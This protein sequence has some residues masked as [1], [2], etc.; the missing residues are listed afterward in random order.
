[1]QTNASNV[2]NASLG[3]AQQINQ[4]S[5]LRQ[6]QLAQL[7]EN[8]K[9]FGKNYMA[10][11][12]KNKQREARIAYGQE[13]GLKPEVLNDEKIGLAAIADALHARATGKAQDFQREQQASEF[14]HSDTQHGIGANGQYDPAGDPYVGRAQ[15]T[16]AA[17]MGMKQQAET[18]ERSRLAP[19]VQSLAAPV[20]EDPYGIPNPDSENFRQNTSSAIPEPQT[21][22][23]RA[24]AGQASGKPYDPDAYAA[25]SK[26]LT[27]AWAAEKTPPLSPFERSRQEAAGRAAGV[28]EKATETPEE[29]QARIKA[30][31]KARAEGTNEGGGDPLDNQ[32]KGLRKDLLGN[33]VKDY[34]SPDVKR[35]KTSLAD[36]EKNLREFEDK[37]A[38]ASMFTDDKKVSARRAQL[39][40]DVAEKKKAVAPKPM[41]AKAGAADSSLKAQ[42]DALPAAEQEKAL[43]LM[44]PEERAKVGR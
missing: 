38:T 41:G 15:A 7:A 29:K 44:T 25:A 16:G 21:V 26:A 22:T 6:Q 33:E 32:I 24:G 23:Q 31:A 28:P 27:P 1:M 14:A 39:E 12:D 36:A 4:Q 37:A 40:A 2:V 34:E 42:F 11:R 8:F 43:K 5:A 3:A 20:V 9:E 30:E 19:Q 18:A 10:Q 13:L 17:E 35:S